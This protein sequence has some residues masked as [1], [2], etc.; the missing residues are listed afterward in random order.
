M[1]ENAIIIDGVKHTFSKRCDVDE[2]PDCYNYCS[3]GERCH[4]HNALTGS[5]LCDALFGDICKTDID[6]LV[7]EI[8]E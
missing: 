7:F 6:K 4:R 8:A 1:N 5:I 2:H 3:L